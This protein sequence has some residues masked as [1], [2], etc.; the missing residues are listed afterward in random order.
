MQKRKNRVIMLLQVK[1]FFKKLV[2]GIW[3]RRRKVKEVIGIKWKMK[4]ISR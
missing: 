1:C 2:N 3:V 4:K